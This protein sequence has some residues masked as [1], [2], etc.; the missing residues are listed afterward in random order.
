MKGIDS[1]DFFLPKVFDVID[2][3]PTERPNVQRISLWLYTTSAVIL[4][5]CCR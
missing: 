2:M 4:S 3:G 1:N 5:R